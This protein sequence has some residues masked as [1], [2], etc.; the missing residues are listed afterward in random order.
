[1]AKET[2]IQFKRETM[3]S[4][5]KSHISVA[6]IFTGSFLLSGF[7]AVE[8]QTVA[9]VPIV[10]PTTRDPLQ[11]PFSSTSIWNT[12][13]GS[14]AVYVPA[15]LPADPR[16]QAWATMPQIDGEIIVLQPAAT[17]TPIQKNSVA[18]QGG[19]RCVPDNATSAPI[20]T[21]P[22]PATFTVPNAGGNNSAAI[23]G[24]DGQTIYQNQPFTRCTVGGGATALLGFPNVNLYGSGETGS[25]GGSGLSAIG[26]SIRLG[27]LRPGGQPPFHALKIEVDSAVVLHTC[28]TRANCYRWPAIGSDSNAVTAYGSL[29]DGTQPVGMQMGALLAIPAKVNLSNLGLLSVPG[30]MLAWTLQNYGA[31][32][33]DSTGGAGFT[34]AAEEGAQGSMLTQFQNDW[35]YPMQDWVIHSNKNPWVHD[36]QILVPLLAV[37][38]NNTAAT[39]GGGGTPLQPLAPPISAH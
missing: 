19:N 10:H 35:G 18:W 27:E 31:Y 15:N 3:I 38:D 39:P 8:A 26:G 21:V 5:I 22:I 16:G 24:A 36:L 12:P 17:P 1:M 11:Q 28:T 4:S 33:V 9:G 29:G 7:Q 14:N 23:L 32:I 37:V 25:H 6:I 34:L 20:Q 13:I 2:Y 30:Q